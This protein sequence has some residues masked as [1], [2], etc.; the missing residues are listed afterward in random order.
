M[1]KENNKF[2]WWNI[3]RLCTSNWHAKPSQRCS[4]SKCSRSDL[5]GWKKTTFRICMR[6]MEWWKRLKAGK[7]AGE[8]L[9][10]T[11]TCT[12]LVVQEIRLS[13]TC[14][15]FKIKCA[16]S[17]AYLNGILPQ[18]FRQTSTY[19]LRKTVYPVPQVNKKKSLSEFSPRAIILWNSLPKNLHD[20]KTLPIFKRRLRDHLKL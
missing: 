19:N 17:P 16:I 13:H 5:H 4:W 20:A 6:T 14:L 3:R 15:I 7:A 10:S 12:A 18:S 9:S 2:L 8:V 1:T 11:S